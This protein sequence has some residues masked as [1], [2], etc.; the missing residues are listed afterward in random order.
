MK[1]YMSSADMIRRRKGPRK[2]RW[3]WKSHSLPGF[4]GVSTCL[5]R[6]RPPKPTAASDLPFVSEPVARDDHLYAAWKRNHDDD[7]GWG[8]Q[9]PFEDLGRPPAKAHS[10]PELPSPSHIIGSVYGP[11][12]VVNPSGKRMKFTAPEDVLVTANALAEGCA[13]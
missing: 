7:Q 3:L 11:S 12:V 9:E 6:G 10:Q 13:V 2:V 1:E 8:V 4:R 5:Q